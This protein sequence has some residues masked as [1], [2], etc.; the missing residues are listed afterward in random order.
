MKRSEAK[1]NITG[2]NDS[3]DRYK[4]S[5]ATSNVKKKIVEAHNTNFSNVKKIETNGFQNVGHTKKTLKV[6][7]NIITSDSGFTFL[8]DVLFDNNEM[9]RKS[10]TTTNS[11]EINSFDIK[12][13]TTINV[14]LKTITSRYNQ[15]EI[16]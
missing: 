15:N 1:E 13:R 11:G 5:N 14:P 9:G 12:I 8:D 6:N 10:H 7:A 2:K 16:W 3:F 4:I